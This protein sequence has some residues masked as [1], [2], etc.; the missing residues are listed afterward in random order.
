VVELPPARAPLL[1][2][3]PPSRD[4]P[5]TELAGGWARLRRGAEAAHSL[6]APPLPLSL[7]APLLPLSCGASHLHRSHSPL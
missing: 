6:F 4:G 1:G 2:S 5:T 3:S 7:S